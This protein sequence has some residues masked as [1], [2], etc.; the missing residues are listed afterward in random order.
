MFLNFFLILAYIFFERFICIGIMLE[1]EGLKIFFIV[2]KM[3]IIEENKIY[4][5]KC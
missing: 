3:S 2:L 4:I 5:F 1:N